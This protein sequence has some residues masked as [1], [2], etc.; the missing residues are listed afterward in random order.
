[1]YYKNEGPEQVNDDLRNDAFGLLITDL[2]NRTSTK[3]QL[4]QD[5]ICPIYRVH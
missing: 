4:V 5:E 3:F 2:V 1:M